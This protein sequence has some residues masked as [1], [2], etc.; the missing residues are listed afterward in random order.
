MLFQRFL[1][2]ERFSI[3]N[4]FLACAFAPFFALSAGAQGTGASL[5][6]AKLADLPATF[7]TLGTNGGP[8]VHLDR[9]EPAN[10]VVVGDAIY[11]FDTGEGTE[12]QMLLAH[13]P[14]AK[15]RAI[16][17]SHH[18]IDHN[19]GLAPLLLSRW[20]LYNQSPLPIIGPPG[21]KDLLKGIAVGYHVSEVAKIATNGMI[22]PPIA[23]T[24]AGVDIA[25]EMN[26]PQLIYSD[27]NIRVLAITNAHYHF[28]QPAGEEPL[29][30]SYSFRIETAHRVFVYTGDTGPSPHVVTLAQDADVLVTESIDVERAAASVR[31]LTKTPAE[32]EGAMVHM[33]ED[34]MTPD[35]IGQMAE[36]AHVKQVVLTHLSGAIDGEKDFTGYIRGIDKYYHGPV[37]L[38]NDADRW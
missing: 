31:R 28:T 3:R 26:K 29:A 25:A 17:I 6:A 13:L 37:H 4:T 11:L 30:R 21:T 9:S 33:R 18:H 16:F 15:L 10:A 20:L 38:A 14:V 23:S 35:E 32:F 5:A 7:V 19:A 22:R 34:H 8:V 12:R 24:L 1:I 2:V 27:E 36:E